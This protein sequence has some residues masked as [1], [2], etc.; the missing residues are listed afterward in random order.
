MFFSSHMTSA[1][2]LQTLCL[3]RNFVSLA[4]YSISGMFATDANFHHGSTGCVSLFV[5]I[6]SQGLLLVQLFGQPLCRRCSEKTIIR[7]RIMWHS[8]WQCRCVLSDKPHFSLSNFHFVLFHLS[9]G[10]MAGPLL[11]SG[12][13]LL[14]EFQCPCG[15]HCVISGLL[16]GGSPGFRSVLCCFDYSPRSVWRFL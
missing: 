5:E 13:Y 11:A 7:V 8:F 15:L 9:I 14:C 3:Q 12:L 10:Y 2:S 4:K 16:A 1:A 6:R